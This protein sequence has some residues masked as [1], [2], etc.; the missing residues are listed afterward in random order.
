MLW[1]K[2]RT[3]QEEP[4]ELESDLEEAILEVADVLFGESRIYLDPKKKI[5]AKGKTR[6]I[7]DGYLID[8]SSAKEPR[9]YVVENELAKHDPLKH[10]AVQ[11]LEFSLSF[12]TSQHLVKSIIKEALANCTSSK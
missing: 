8:L 9:L 5:G 2:E 4:F 10:I 12:E 6:N 7:P 11:I 1:N 3:Y